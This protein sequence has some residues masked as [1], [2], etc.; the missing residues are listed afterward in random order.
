ML[1]QGWSLE[2]RSSCCCQRAR[3]RGLSF[4]RRCCCIA[5]R[6]NTSASHAIRCPHFH[7]TDHERSKHARAHKGIVKD[8]VR[9]KDS[10]QH[11]PRPHDPQADAASRRSMLLS[12]RVQEHGVTGCRRLMPCQPRFPARGG[13]RRSLGCQSV[14]DAEGV[15]GSEEEKLLLGLLVILSFIASH[16]AFSCLVC[17]SLAILWVSLFSYRCTR[18]E[19]THRIWATS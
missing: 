14:S 10:R 13:G 6:L 2:R 5:R 4:Q 9:L 8:G 12:V 16:I 18:R 11:Q 19:P 3:S 15:E 7:V 1:L 17:S